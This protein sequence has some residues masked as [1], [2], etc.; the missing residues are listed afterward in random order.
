MSWDEVSIGEWERYAQSPIH[1]EMVA[2]R[3]EYLEAQAE[4]AYRLGS[5]PLY[6]RLATLAVR[7]R[8]RVV[9]PWSTLESI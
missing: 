4:K 2:A 7:I 3:V 5:L 1:D 6:T 8:Q 9:P